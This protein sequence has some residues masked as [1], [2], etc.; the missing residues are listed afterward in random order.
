MIFTL[1]LNMVQPN[2]YTRFFE[3]QA[4]E[5]M[6]PGKVLI[7]YG[8]RRAGKTELIKKLVKKWQGTIYTGKG[9]DMDLQSLFVT[10]SLAKLSSFFSAYDL[11]IIDEAQYIPEIGAGLKLLVDSFPEK[12]FIVSGSSSFTLA[13]Q[14]GEPLTGRNKVRILYPVSALELNNQFGAME[15]IH[16]RD[17]LLIYGSYPEVLNCSANTDKI[18]YLLTLRDSYL[19]KDI[20]Q[21]EDIRYAQKINDL[22][23]LLAFQIGHEVSLN[24]LSNNLAISRQT[25]ERYLDLLQQTF[26]IKKVTG[27]SRNL[28]SEI[29]KS[30]RYYF[31]DNGI[32]NA[33]IN[34]FNPHGS[35][36]DSGMLWENFLFIER[37]KK[38]EYQRIYSNIYFWR[39]YSG[40]EID[41]VE[42]REGKLFGYEFKWGLKKSRPPQLWLNTY[43]ES[44][45]E[46]VN[47]EDFLGFIT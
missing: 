19:L 20:L 28:R 23:K 40:Q 29:S 47:R 41:H 9:D 46:V 39:N 22:L 33:L 13:G 11:I 45:Y 37:L 21:L 4:D 8:P 7:I 5:L 14:V 12:R 36:D 16:K 42:E 24:E 43:P 27:F 26:I 38:Q 2:W 3:N 44:S 17:E 1:T 10:R 34:N 30:S 15:L 18:E 25:V 31:W 32:R 6:Q 35:R